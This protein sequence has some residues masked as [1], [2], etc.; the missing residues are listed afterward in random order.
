MWRRED[1]SDALGPVPGLQTPVLSVSDLT[2]VHHHP[3]IK[4]VSPGLT[5]QD[6]NSGP[7]DSHS[8]GLEGGHSRLLRK[9]KNTVPLLWGSSGPTEVV[10]NTDKLSIPL[11]SLTGGLL[12]GN[13]IPGMNKI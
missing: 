6:S 13:L 2:S 11:K 9:L 8:P 10:G 5:W 3:P 1:L 7:P 4:G 12:R